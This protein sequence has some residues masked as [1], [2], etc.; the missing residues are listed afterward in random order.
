MEIPNTTLL[1]TGGASGNTGNSGGDAK[2]LYIHI[3]PGA[4]TANNVVAAIETEGTFTAKI[5]PAD[6]TL[7]ALAGTG[8][9]DI[10]A[11]AT[12]SGGSGTTLDKNSGI[13]VVNGSRPRLS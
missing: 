1:V 12:T 11:T 7:A 2:T 9:V 3:D 5:D 6:T 4:T 8:L 13:R 10:N